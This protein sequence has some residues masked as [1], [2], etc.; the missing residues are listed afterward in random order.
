MPQPDYVSP[1]GLNLGPSYGLALEHCQLLRDRVRRSSGLDV[2]GGANL[3]PHASG[4][5][6]FIVDFLMDH[7]N[8]A[9]RAY[10]AEVRYVYPTIHVSPPAPVQRSL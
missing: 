7:A 9:H 3:R 8:P 10:L 6:T 1:G 2:P 4:P 5:G